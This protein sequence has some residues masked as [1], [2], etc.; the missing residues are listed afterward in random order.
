MFYSVVIPRFNKRYKHFDFQTRWM[1]Y[2][3][4]FALYSSIEVVT[5]MFVAWYL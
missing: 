3:I 1:I 5:D 2:W 4:V